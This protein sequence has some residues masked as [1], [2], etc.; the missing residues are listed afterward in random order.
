MYYLVDKYAP[1]EDGEGPRRLS[2]EEKVFL[3]ALKDHTATAIQQ[4]L[5]GER[6]STPET[7]K[8][9]F[10]DISEAMAMWKDLA[11]FETWSWAL[12]GR[13]S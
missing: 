4:P 6:K 13:G 2:E 9:S 5:V 7:T 12:G 1:F 10:L 3:S 8:H 11:K